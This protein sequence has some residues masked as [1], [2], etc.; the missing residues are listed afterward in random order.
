MI[1]EIYLRD[2]INRGLLVPFHYYAI[3]DDTDYEQIDYRNGRY[4][5]EQ[6]EKALSSNKR[7]ALVLDKFTKFSGQ[8]CLGFCASIKHAEFM[9]EYFSQNKVPACVV[10]S[11]QASSPYSLPRQEAIKQLQEGKLRVIFNVDLFS[12]EVDIPEVDLVMFLRP[13]E[14]YVV[15]LQQL[16]RGLR[17][18]QG[19]EYLKVL[20]FIGNYKRA[21]HIPLLL[22]GKNHMAVEGRKLG[23]PHE[24]EHPDECFANFDFK[25]IDLF[26][27]MRKRDPISQR[28]KEEYWR[29]AKQLGR[30]PTR[31]DVFEGIDT[32]INHFL[33]G[34]GWLGFLAS[35]GEL[36]EEEQSWLKTPA[37]GFLREM[38][39]TGMVKSYKMP[40]LLSFLAGN[41]MLPAANTARIAECWRDFYSDPVHEQDMQRDKSTRTWREWDDERLAK[42][43][44]KNPVHF[45]TQSSKF[46]H[47]DEI[48]KMFSI[49]ESVRP[50]LSTR[51][52]EHFRD[53]LTWRSKNYYAVRYKK[54]GVRGCIFCEIPKESVIAENQYA[55]AI[56]DKF[57]VNQGHALIIPKRHFANFFE[58]TPEEIMAIYEL[59]KVV[60]ERIDSE[61]KPDGYN[62]GVN[63]GADAG[64]TVMHLH[65]HLIPRYKGDVDRPRGG[66]RNIKP[67]LVP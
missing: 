17:K 19:K 35:L 20:D 66:I 9:A 65:V 13:T 23:L 25:L 7:A 40:T 39:R 60:K 32:P 34:D 43:A 12:E 55:L 29:L 18:A 44:V 61:L 54:G 64:Q 63:I 50:Y 26:A 42:L 16:G 28:I 31:L 15:F 45:L 10:H 62:L 57:P 56:Y 46:F 41:S 22:A 11:G 59:L 36:T 1:Y 48:N 30:R 8:K 37:A 47:Y 2:A 49:D 27:E 53:I 3:Y 21:H 58:A 6:L 24:I 33:K 5:Q 51:L 38:E 14:S 4:D 52:A 67:N